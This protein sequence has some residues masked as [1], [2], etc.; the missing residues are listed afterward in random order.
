ML[1]ERDVLPA[2]LVALSKGLSR[3][4]SGDE[5]RQKLKAKLD[6]KIQKQRGKQVGQQQRIS[7]EHKRD[8][9][10]FIDARL[11]PILELTAAFANLLGASQRQADRPFRELVAAWVK[12][13]TLKEDY[14]TQEFNHFFQT[15]GSDMATFALWA[16][17][18]LKPASV[19]VFLRRLHEVPV[20]PQ[21]L[22]SDRSDAGSQDANARSR[23]GASG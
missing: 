6:K 22:N 4:M 23:G 15:L 13:R 10:R 11:V 14:S 2:E 9:D 1:H 5:F 20:A 3:S 18:D 19:R 16:R 7:P 21:V 17:S 12:V 8:L